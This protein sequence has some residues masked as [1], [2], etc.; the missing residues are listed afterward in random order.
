[1][2]LET[3]ELWLSTLRL[4]KQESD[5][6]RRQIAVLAGD[7]VAEQERNRAPGYSLVLQL[8][9]ILGGYYKSIDEDKAKSPFLPAMCGMIDT[10][11][12][13]R[14]LSIDEMATFQVSLAQAMNAEYFVTPN[15]I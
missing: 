2:D 10:V 7:L 1:M 14:A 3:A 5:S 4:H 11:N 8:A 6:L 15:D 9:K 13:G 12:E